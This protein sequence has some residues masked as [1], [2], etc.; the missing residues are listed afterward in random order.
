MG[1]RLVRVTHDQGDPVRLG[2]TTY[3]PHTRTVQVWLPGGAAGLV[4]CHP[5][6]LTVET[7][8]GASHTF[9]IPDVTRM[10]QLG[11]I[12]RTLAGAG[13][14]SLVF[15]V[16]RKRNDRRKHTHEPAEQR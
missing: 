9:S 3:T 15:F 6:M 2:D 7:S 13:L 11:I 1:N 8:D 10:V 12:I 4:W 16:R 5:R 14:L